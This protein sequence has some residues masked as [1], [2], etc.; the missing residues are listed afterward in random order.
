MLKKLAPTLAFLC[1]LSACTN[2][3]DGGDTDLLETGDET[4]SGASSDPGESTESGIESTGDGDGDG[5]GDGEA[6][7]EHTFV[8]GSR[9]FY[10]ADGDV[11][12][13]IDVSLESGGVTFVSLTVDTPEL[14]LVEV[15][16]PERLGFAYEGDVTNEEGNG[17]FVGIA[18]NAHRFYVD[19]F[20]GVDLDVLNLV[21]Y[22]VPTTTAPDPYATYELIS[23]D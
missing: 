2:P 13:R 20:A 21:D 4:G 23:L 14:G 19:D 7:C 1:A 18:E 16:D 5:D 12:V 15:T 9:N 17:T 11:C 8:E 22:S 10:S 6:F 3:D